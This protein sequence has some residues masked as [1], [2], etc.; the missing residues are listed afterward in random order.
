VDEVD[1]LR[2]RAIY[3]E[4]MKPVGNGK[5]RQ[6]ALVDRLVSLTDPEMVEEA[7]M[8]E[9]WKAKYKRKITVRTKSLWERRLK[10]DTREVSCG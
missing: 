1:I 5:R 8:L 3:L 10:S 6:T 7:N 9:S 4:V 2:A